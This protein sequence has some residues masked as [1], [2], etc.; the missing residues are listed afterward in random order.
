MESGQSKVAM[1]VRTTKRRYRVFSI[2]GALTFVLIIAAI[3]IP[4]NMVSRVAHDE[5]SAMES[6]H[7]LRDLELQYAAAHPSK[8]FTCDFALLKT[9]EHPSASGLKDSVRRG[10]TA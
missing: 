4:H 5:A 9:E 3:W 2:L 8:G 7:A 1:N 10:R 6:L